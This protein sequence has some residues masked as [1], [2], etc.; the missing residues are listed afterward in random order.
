M[1]ILKH[2]KEHFMTGNPC[3][4]HESLLLTIMLLRISQC[5]GEKT[6]KLLEKNEDNMLRNSLPRQVLI[7]L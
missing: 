7:Q 3:S 1:A 2:F 5:K 4:Q 6:E